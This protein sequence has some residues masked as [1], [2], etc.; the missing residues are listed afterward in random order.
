MSKTLSSE[1]ISSNVWP[2]KL[3]ICDV[4]LAI[5]G[6]QWLIRPD[7][8]TDYVRAEIA[9]ALRRNI[10]VI[11]ILI[12]DAGMPKADQLPSD[13]KEF[14]ERQGFEIRYHRF[15]SDVQSLCL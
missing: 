8:P 15:R 3:S 9:A 6:P 7:D 13:L 2:R 5:I 1:P 4:F 11:P 12:R 10:R 14:A